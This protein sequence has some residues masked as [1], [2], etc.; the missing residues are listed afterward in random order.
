MAR[1]LLANQRPTF[2][3]NSLLHNSMLMK[4]DGVLGEITVPTCMKAIQEVIATIMARNIS[5]N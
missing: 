4:S 3:G 5:S 1:N 2:G